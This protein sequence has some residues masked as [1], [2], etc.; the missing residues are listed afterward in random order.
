MIRN[1][2]LVG[3]ILGLSIVGVAQQSKGAIS[4]HYIAAAE[5]L[6]ADNFAA[7][8]TSLSAL[9]KESQGVLKTQADTAAN[10]PTIT[11]LRTAIKPLS[12]TVITMELP[13]G[14]GVAFCPMF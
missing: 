11:A 12:E 13:K 6:A 1:V 5:A 14:Y 4:P 7:A 9:A 8:K 3:L 10:A 2:L